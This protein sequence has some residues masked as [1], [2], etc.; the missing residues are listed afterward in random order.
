MNTPK[1]LRFSL[2]RCEARKQQLETQV[3]ELNRA[4][5]LDAQ[6]KQHLAELQT[7]LERTQ[8]T[9][10]SLQRQLDDLMD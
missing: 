5:I 8:A 2:E 1:E 3:S 7:D 4:D 9:A 10:S 6:Q